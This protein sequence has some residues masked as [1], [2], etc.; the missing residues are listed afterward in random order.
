[1]PEKIALDVGYNLQPDFVH[2]HS[3]D[4]G[5]NTVQNEYASNCQ[6]HRYHKAL[7]FCD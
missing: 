1:M 5:G 2:Q 6:R 4:I 7:F 3:M